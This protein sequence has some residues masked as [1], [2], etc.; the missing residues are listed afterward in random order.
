M[1]VA[2]VQAPIDWESVNKKKEQLKASSVEYL[3]KAINE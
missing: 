3:E 2:D 1:T